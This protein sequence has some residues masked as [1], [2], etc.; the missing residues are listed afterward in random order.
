MQLLIYIG[1]EASCLSGWK[2]IV[3]EET[4]SR[5]T[6]ATKFFRYLLHLNNLQYFVSC[7][8]PRLKMAK[9]LILYHLLNQPQN[10]LTRLQKD[11]PL[12]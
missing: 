9:W 4:V 11:C 2:E 8:P 1:R 5:T 12:G 7:C 10:S 3:G 6:S